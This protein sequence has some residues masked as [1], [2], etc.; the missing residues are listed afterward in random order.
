MSERKATALLASLLC[1]LLLTGVARAM[2]SASHAINWDV[3]GGGGRP[4]SSA[5][6]AMNSTVGQAAVGA[7]SNASYRLGAGYWYGVLAPPPP[8]PGYRIYLPIVLKDYP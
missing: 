1:C 4:I 8:P 3:I 7:L 5:G 6:Y 2:S